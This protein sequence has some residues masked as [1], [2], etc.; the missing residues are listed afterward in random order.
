MKGYKYQK[1]EEWL[2]NPQELTL[3]FS[4]IESILGFKLPP[5]ASEYGQWWENDES[6][7]QAKAWLSAG[8]K[9]INASHIPDNEKVTFVKKY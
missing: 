9:T 1:L 8:Y 2:K 4:Q 7:S 3:T 6:H 5:S